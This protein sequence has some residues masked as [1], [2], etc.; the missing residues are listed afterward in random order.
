MSALQLSEEVHGCPNLNGADD[1]MGDEPYEKGFI[2]PSDRKDAE[3]RK[4]GKRWN[5]V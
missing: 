4:A 3:P 1:S 2:S 5:Q